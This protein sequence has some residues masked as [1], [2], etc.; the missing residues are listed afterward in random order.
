MSQRGLLPTWGW[1]RHAKT[2][3]RKCT[4]FI[5]K[6]L[7]GGC[8]CPSQSPSET[9]CWCVL[10]C[11]CVRKHTP[12]AFLLLESPQEY[13][14][15]PWKRAGRSPWRLLYKG[16]WLLQEAPLLSTFPLPACKMDTQLPDVVATGQPLGWEPQAKEAE[17]A[18][19][20]R[21][22]GDSSQFWTPIWE[23]LLQEW[24]KKP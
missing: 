12:W 7:L 3:H 9:Q 17:E 13:I 14:L 4:R 11:V 18:G 8:P 10:Q 6:E 16:V 2:F 23:I 19:L 15:P 5:W 20:W 22:C 21:H 1:Q 24:E